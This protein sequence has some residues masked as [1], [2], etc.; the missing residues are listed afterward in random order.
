MMGPCAL[1]ALGSGVTHCINSRTITCIIAVAKRG[2]IP[3]LHEI[4]KKSQGK[5]CLGPQN[6]IIFISLKKRKKEIEARFAPQTLPQ[7]VGK[8]FICHLGK[9]PKWY[10][11]L[12]QMKLPVSDCAGC[13]KCL[14]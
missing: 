8:S 14:G 1:S 13:Q 4:F 2:Q 9:Y 7:H 11:P 3:D 12:I 6:K 5:P 10:S